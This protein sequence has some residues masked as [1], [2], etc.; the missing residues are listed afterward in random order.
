ML[1]NLVQPCISARWSALLNSH[2]HID[3]APTY[4]TLPALTT[5]C[6]ASS[7][8][9]IGVRRSSRWI[10]YRSMKSV[11]SRRRLWSTSAMIAL[12]DSPTL[13]GPSRIGP[14]TFVAITTSSRGT[15]RS[16]IARPRNSSLEPP[17]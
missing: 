6:S 13:L 10:W 12:R 17:E 14:F 5:S 7:V 1:T 15:P 4:R 11:P 8:S 2:A 9:S 16:L 3:D